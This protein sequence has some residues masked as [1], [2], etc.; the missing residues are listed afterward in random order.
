MISFRGLTLDEA[1]HQMAA[2]ETDE[3]RRGVLEAALDVVVECACR[4][5]TTDPCEE[6]AAGE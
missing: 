2:A 1:L 3:Y 4:Q 6:E 5:G